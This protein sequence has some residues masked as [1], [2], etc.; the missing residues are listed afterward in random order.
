[1][2]SLTRRPHEYIVLVDEVGETIGRFCIA[3]V[4]GW[5]VKIGFDFPPNIKIYRSE[6][7]EQQEAA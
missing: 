5:Q 2:L 3:N 4:K 1:M 6:L 7:L